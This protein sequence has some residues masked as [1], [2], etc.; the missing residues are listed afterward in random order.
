MRKWNEDNIT[1]EVEILI[2]QYDRFPSAKFLQDLGRWDLFRA[3]AKSGG[4]TFYRKKLNFSI[5]ER[6]HWKNNY[7][8]EIEKIVE[9]PLQS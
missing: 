6:N 4:F 7:K 1:H 5:T 8:T 2:K 9:N 3:I